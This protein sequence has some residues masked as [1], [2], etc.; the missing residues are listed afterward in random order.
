MKIRSYGIQGV[1]L[2]WIKSFLSER[3]QKVQVNGEY[4][5]WRDVT[6][7]IPQ[8]SVLR[9]ILFVLYINDLPDQISSEI[10]LFADDTKVFQHIRSADDSEGLQRDLDVLM[11]WSNVWLLKF[12]PDE[13][14][15]MTVGRSNEERQYH[16]K[17]ATGDSPLEQIDN[18][19]DLGVIIDSNLS[20]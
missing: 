8:D 14:K 20:F 17:Q 10:Y 16:L 3:K 1:I 15:L 9:P 13:C 7:G 18:E 12:H 5:G 2:Q 19:K 11:D 6:S 4:S